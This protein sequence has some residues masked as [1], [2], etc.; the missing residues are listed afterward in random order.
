MKIL[1]VILLVSGFFSAVFSGGKS[2]DFNGSW[3]TGSDGLILTFFAQDSLQVGNTSDESVK[4]YGVYKRTD[5]TFSAMVKN[6]DITMEM[7]YRYLSKSTDT[8][9]A[10]A[11]YFLVDGD[12]VQVPTEWM[13]MARCKI[14]STTTPKVEKNVIPNSKGKK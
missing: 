11:I 8:V 6:G 10:Q 13:D 14:H 12:S 1:T 9:S 4:G 7:K 2:V 3:C 5:S